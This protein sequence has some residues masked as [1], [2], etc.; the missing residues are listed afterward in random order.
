MHDVRRILGSRVFGREGK[1]K[2]FLE[3]PRK[4]GVGGVGVMSKKLL[5]EEEG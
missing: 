1:K 5:K 2:N 3:D 4:N